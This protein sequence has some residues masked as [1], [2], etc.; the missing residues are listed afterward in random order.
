MPYTLTRTEILRFTAFYREVSRQI[1]GE[2][3][4][5]AKFAKVAIRR[6]N[7]FMDESEPEDKI[8]DAMISMEALYLYDSE[9]AELSYRLSLRAACLLG[10][11]EGEKNYIRKLLKEV[12]DL[13]SKVVHG[14]N[15]TITG[16]DGNR[17]PTT[18]ILA[19]L[20]EYLR[21]SIRKFLLLTEEKLSHNSILNLLDAA[22]LN[23]GARS[24]IG[25]GRREVGWESLFNR[26][27]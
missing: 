21:W 17:I 8:M 5:A 24:L 13:R 1:A 10:R 18:D 22:V 23:P 12:Y 19:K 26:E 3:I 20:E 2:G 11:D 27:H 9:N 25:A 4:D 16:L 15:I 7:V 6:F 14:R